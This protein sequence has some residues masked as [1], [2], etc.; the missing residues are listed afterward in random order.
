MF[1]YLNVYPQTIFPW[2]TH[3]IGCEVELGIRW[4]DAE[5]VHEGVTQEECERIIATKVPSP[6]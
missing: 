6:Y 3:Q 4:G 5:V 1:Y 2:L